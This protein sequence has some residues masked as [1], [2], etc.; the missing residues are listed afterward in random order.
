ML[1]FF[2][3]ISIIRI[4]ASTTHCLIEKTSDGE[5]VLLQV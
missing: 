1:E 4:F 3:L 5:N 2:T